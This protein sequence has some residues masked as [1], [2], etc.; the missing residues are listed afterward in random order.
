MVK[1]NSPCI[2]LVCQFVWEVAVAHGF[3]KANSCRMIGSVPVSWVSIFTL[4]QFFVRAGREDGEKFSPSLGA[5]GCPSQRLAFISVVFVK[6]P[7]WI[8]PFNPVTSS[9]FVAPSHSV[10]C[11][12]SLWLTQRW[13]AFLVFPDWEITKLIH[14][15]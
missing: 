1:I 4:P 9:T 8:S 2:R 3:L 15:I 11:S 6:I 10:C 12:S 14:L 7:Q 5:E 13:N